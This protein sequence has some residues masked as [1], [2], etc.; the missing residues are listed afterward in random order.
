MKLELDAFV[1]IEDSGKPYPKIFLS[2]IEAV[3]TTV[4]LS[5]N[6]TKAYRI[7]L[8]EEIETNKPI[9]QCQLLSSTE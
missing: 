5:F 9:K 8:Q 7:F 6:D 4:I 1:I 2:E 3:K